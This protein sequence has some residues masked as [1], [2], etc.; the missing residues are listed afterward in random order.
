MA[1]RFGL[2]VGSDTVKAVIVRENNTVSTLGIFRVQGQPVR[3]V[4]EVLEQALALREGDQ[5]VCGVTG[6][7]ASTIAGL[8]G[9]DKIH[10]P[11]AIAAAI[12]K[13]Y[14][15]V[16]TVIEMGRE[17]QKY[18]LFERDPATGKLLVEDSNLG[19]KCAS[20]SGS[21]VD[22]M[23]K[24]LNYDGVEEFA[25]VALETQSPASL[26][27]RCAVF[28][29]SDIT[30]LYQKGTPRNRI[31]AGVHQAI[32]R[33]YRSAIARGKEF[34]DRI[35]FIG[36][37]SENPAVRKY[38]AEELGLDG[39]L[40][41]PE[42][43]RTLGAIGAAMRAQ[44]PI[45]LSEAIEK[46]EQHLSRPLDY[47][48]CEPITLSESELLWDSEM[49]LDAHGSTLK[50]ADCSLDIPRAALGVDIGSVSTKAALVT[51]VD[52]QTIV[53]ASYYRRTDGDPL[54]AV[55]DTL[56][57]IKDQ[58]DEKGYRI[59]KIAAATTG[60][61]RYL[62]GDYIGA[63]LVRNEITAQASGALAYADDVDTIF[64]IGGQDSKY[65]RLDGDVIIDFEMNKA[66]A[67]GTGAF[68]EKQA[69]RLGIP[70][71]DFGDT[72]I[73]NTRPPDL[74]WTCTVFS[75]SAMVYYQ[76]NNVPVEDLAAGICLASVK[77]YLHKN[78][79]SREIGAKVAFQGAVAFNKGMVAAYETILGRKIVVP[80]YPH[81]TGAVGAARL[82]Y[83]A[84]PEV[85]TFRG[86]DHV[87]ETKYE[88]TSFE[89]KGCSNRCDVN[90]FQMEDG[91]KYFY[92]DRCEKFS[93]VQKKNLGVGLPD[94]F[95]EREEMMMNAYKGA[96]STQNPTPR[97]PRV[98]VPRGLM[99][100]EYYP[101]YAAFLGELGFEVVPSE[102]TNKRIVE[103]GLD[104]AIGEPCF[105]FKV[106]HGHYMDLIE[107]GVDIIFAP[108]IIS[109]EQPNPNMRQAQTCP[110]LQGA[111]DVISAAVGVTER[112]IRH[113][114]PVLHFKR[115]VRHLRKV[116]RRAGAELGCSPRES[117][118]AFEVGL[119]TLQEFRRKVDARGAEVL[120][121]LSAD[122]M[123]F[124]VVGRPYTL[125]DPAV[126]MDIGKKIQDLGI[127]AIPQ[128]FLPLD[129]VDI[130]DVWPNAYS[131]QI[132]KKLMAA[133]LIRQDPRLRAVV[134]TYFAC[135]PD[136]F[137]NPFFKDEIGEPCYVMQIDEHT[138]DAGVITRIEAFADTA[139][140]SVER[141]YETIR[142][143]DSEIT[144]LDDRKLWIP[145]AN[146]SSRM[147]AAVMQAYGIRA[148]ALPRSPDVGLGLARRA[149]SEDV[150]LPALMTTEDM[151][152]RVNQP[153]F[154]P[155]KEAF[156]QG[157]SEG[158]C[159]FGMYSM[160]QRRILDKLGLPEVDIVTLGSIS[161][162]G[163]MGR[164]FALCA[165]DA[166][167]THDLLFKMLLRT[168]PY[169][170]QKGRS[171]EL[172]EEYLQRLIRLIPEHKRQVESNKIGT[173]IS[174]KHLGDF[175]EL[176]RRAQEDFS[177]I[178][179]SHGDRP[180]VGV[181]GEFYVRLH[182]GAN[183]D[184]LRKLEA[185]GAET[186][187]APATEFF[188][189]ANFI[190][191]V[192]SGDRLKDGGWSRQELSEWV[193]RA[194]N[195]RLAA[196]AEHVLYHASLPFLKDCEDIGPGEVISEGSK[197]VNYN[198]GGEAIC[199]MGKSED[200]AK[201]GLAGIVSVIPFNC[202]PGNTVTALSQSLRR[203]H[204][205]IP[206]LNLDYDGFVDATRDSKI[207]SFMW[208][209][210]ERFAGQQV[211]GGEVVARRAES[212]QAVK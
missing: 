88:M 140:K 170:T 164:M 91:P 112:G 207:T 123:A 185:D 60:S 44:T 105:P 19:N 128:D 167:V 153:D 109:G 11:N 126:N 71:E 42:H 211:S 107:K 189:Y 84:D 193:A 22:H 158:P 143:T 197:Y 76:Q 70:L 7:G 39:R 108:R 75:E 80:P 171:E 15:E 2:D 3:R 74:D 58:I 111:P 36:G 165:W 21:F 138:A 132:Q 66:C 177:G 212:I 61:G 92:N 93:A 29:E 188:S 121:N 146:E 136:S 50:S 208:Q 127:L 59:G 203:R 97:T 125:W 13:L 131:R 82:A 87:A 115:G 9:V 129:V 16:R 205:N 6:G 40:F 163:G 67:A 159:R 68:L 135:G 52:G 190:G 182:D 120:A 151:L 180:L 181:V 90:T 55:R 24:R 4:K 210:K 192:L 200:F 54:A 86:F 119:K 53:L 103:M 124:I 191:G 155:N 144:R 32:S 149:I 137:G 169:E 102:P 95:A 25:Q 104:T 41:V 85:S 147:L 157:N 35:A 99:F 152:Y 34:R 202:M 31:A 130:S 23:A 1:L 168:R 37:V 72:A 150:C 173:L 194:V 114:S 48:G 139:V 142:T 62:T 162:H 38:L 122:Q 166:F 161:E 183:Q 73:K 89:C 57:K 69:E 145:Y 33:N 79:A 14:P 175:E 113:I 47:P 110:Y 20:G 174:T 96:R 100:S 209:V 10:E 198:F 8:I 18:I 17:A 30:H 81:I 199:S 206:F 134:L 78:V 51:M 141:Q 195:V 187:L 106:A 196:K 83:I 154:D 49:A 26:S 204:N 116:F 176:L 186:W 179:R 98:G 46:L 118:A 28:T 63:D 56:S 156:F 43:N 64:E 172:F 160:L 101:L 5:I 65:I 178:P 77:N 12:D 148:E 117:A 27:G 201:R 133:R 45:S 94:L 184:I